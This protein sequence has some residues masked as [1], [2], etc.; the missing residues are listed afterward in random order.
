ME[1]YHL[2][3]YLDEQSF[4]Y[5]HRKNMGDAARFWIAWPT[6]LADGSLGATSLGVLEG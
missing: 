5:N 1:P 2:F 3:R 6:R 4:R